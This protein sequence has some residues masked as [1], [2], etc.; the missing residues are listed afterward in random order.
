[1]P[2][3]FYQEIDLIIYFVGAQFM[4]PWGRDKS[5]PHGI[6]AGIA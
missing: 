2:A 3:I 5:R 4:A 1:M 6:M